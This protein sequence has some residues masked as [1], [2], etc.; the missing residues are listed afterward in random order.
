MTSTEEAM[1]TAAM[2]Q[3]A[4]AAQEAQRQQPTFGTLLDPTDAL[5]GGEETPGRH[6]LVLNN[7][8]PG[9]LDVSA[10]RFIPEFPEQIEELLIARMQRDM[11]GAAVPGPAGERV[12]DWATLEILQEG[13]GILTASATS[14]ADAADG[15]AVYLLQVVF[16][17]ELQPSVAEEQMISGGTFVEDIAEELAATK[18][19][20]DTVA[21]MSTVDDQV[22]PAEPEPAAKPTGVTAEYLGGYYGSTPFAFGGQNFVLDWQ[23]YKAD[24]TT[25]EGLVGFTATALASDGNTYDTYAWFDPTTGISVARAEPATAE[26]AS[27]AAA[28]GEEPQAAEFDPARHFETVLADELR[29]RWKMAGDRLD[30]VGGQHYDVKGLLDGEPGCAL[31][32][33]EFDGEQYFAD[34]GAHTESDD[35]QPVTCR[36]RIRDAETVWVEREETRY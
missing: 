10:A 13:N 12:V 2:S 22:A 19:T 29:D 16:D 32:Y 34:L 31:E 28:A 17:N 14:V 5:W 15:D 33:R 4:E 7:E 8:V 6:S 36:L 18:S 27:E 9:I 11:A 20:V 30:E 23:T 21:N 26:S 25:P 24:Q 1:D 3:L 35:R